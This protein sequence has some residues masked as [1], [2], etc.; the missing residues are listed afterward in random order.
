MEREFLKSLAETRAMEATLTAEIRAA[1]G[2][3]PSDSAS[4]RRGATG[5]QKHIQELANR[6]D[7]LQGQLASER[8]RFSA[9]HNGWKVRHRVPASAW[10]LTYCSTPGRCHGTSIAYR[11]LC[12]ALC[13]QSSAIASTPLPCG[14]SCMQSDS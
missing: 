3:E 6:V 13:H 10:R 8:T 4:T 9:L 2:T 14:C 11:V 12:Y 5:Q 7:R 1:E